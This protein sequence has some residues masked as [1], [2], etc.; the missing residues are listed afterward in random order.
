MT[1]IDLFS[2]IGGF[3]LGLE[4]AGFQFDQ[5]FFSEIEKHAIANYKYHFPD[6]KHIG[7]VTHIQP[8]NLPKRNVVLTFGSPCQGFSQAGRGL[9]LRDNRS[10]LL[11]Q[12]LSLID[13]IRP[14]VFVWENVKGAITRK[15]REDFW[16]VLQAIADIG[17]Y[18]VE[19]QLVNTSWI[20]PQ[21][22]ERIL[23]IGHHTGRSR[24]KVF[25][26][27]E[28]DHLSFQR[29]NQQ[30]KTQYCATTIEPKMDRSHAT[31][32]MQKGRGFNKGGV[33]DTI[34]TITS[35]KWQDNHFV[36]DARMLQE[37]TLS[38]LGAGGKE[39]AYHI[40]RLTEIECE[41]A[42]GFPDD[43]TKIGNYEGK[44]KEIA[45]TNRYKMIGNAVTV[46]MIEAIGKRLR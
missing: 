19:W 12:A 1:L 21:N 9:G 33:H 8:R 22:R 32:I 44:L 30:P 13:A 46:D 41:R 36:I 24:P 43:W 3:H 38:P 39:H 20:L 14:D 10:G 18:D 25:P 42:Q 31:F 4:R 29:A 26:F 6:A 7:S 35:Q 28:D 2:G 15:H 17:A 45:M 37:R 16:A 11:R 40:R 27:R 5:V 34:P 23:L